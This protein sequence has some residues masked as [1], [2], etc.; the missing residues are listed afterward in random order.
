MLIFVVV[1]RFR[2][3]PNITTLNKDNVSDPEAQF[4]DYIYLL[5]T[6]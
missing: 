2:Y 4:V 1:F 6:E 3:L 5:Q